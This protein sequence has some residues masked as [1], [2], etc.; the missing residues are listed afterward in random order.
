[1][2]DDSG[3]VD[4]IDIHEPRITLAKPLVVRAV[5]LRSR[6]QR[7]QECIDHDAARVERLVLQ[8]RQPVRLQL[9]PLDG[10]LLDSL[11]TCMLI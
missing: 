6:T 11:L 4:A 3:T 1:V 8:L 2:P 7:E 5:V 9:R 10:M